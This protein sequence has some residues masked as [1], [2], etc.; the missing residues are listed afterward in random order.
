[1]DAHTMKNSD[2][3]SLTQK[4]IYG[5]FNSFCTERIE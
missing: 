5:P 2:S 1:M 3:Y 4:N